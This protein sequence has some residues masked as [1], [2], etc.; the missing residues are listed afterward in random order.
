M[1]TRSNIALKLND[2]R[3]LS[4]YCHWD[5][6]PEHHFPILTK[7]YNT[8]E[9]VEALIENGDISSLR[10]YCTKPEGHS[11]EDPVDDYTIY[12]GRDRGASNV[13]ARIKPIDRWYEEDYGYLFADGKWQVWKSDKIYTDYDTIIEKWKIDMTKL[14]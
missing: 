9:K 5:G 7:H 10:K 4:I 8:L 14:D 13:H 1:A 2:D 6:Y 3:V 11:F 12:Y